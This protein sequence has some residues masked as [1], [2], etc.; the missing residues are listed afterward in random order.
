MWDTSVSL[1]AL[2][3]PLIFLKISFLKKHNDRL[4]RNSKERGKRQK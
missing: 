1:P 2:F 4:K 3:L